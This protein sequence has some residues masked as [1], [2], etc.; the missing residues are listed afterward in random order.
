DQGHKMSKSLGNVIA[1][2]DVIKQMG[3]EIVRLWVASA[4]TTSDV[5]VSKKILQ[6]AAEAYRKIRN[7][8]RYMLANTSDFDPKANAVDFK[9][10]GSVDQY[11]LV[12]LNDLVA[13]CLMAYDHFDFTSVY[14]QVFS[15][16]SND[17]SAFYL[18]FA[19]DVLYIDAADSRSR[20]SMQT[21]IYAALVKL[22]KLL[23]PILPHT[24]EE[25]WSY[26]QEPEAYAQLADMPVVENY[27]NADE[28][29]TN[30]AAFMDLRS[31]V[32][33]ALE[34][35]R[36]Q[37][38]IGKSFEAKLTL[39]PTAETKAVLDKL[40]ANVQQILI[41]SQLTIADEPAP[42]DTE[43]FASGAVKVEHAQGEVCPRCRMIKND[44]G[45]DK[46]LPML[47]ARCAQIVADNYPAALTEGLDK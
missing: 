23:T 29:K 36:D 15:F 42:A 31:D 39:Y 13:D 8:M 25:V 34:E 32:L 43:Q 6:Q 9:D 17:L 5:A 40:A 45:T 41:I 12:K 11:M 2:S 19:K 1:P 21:V 3:A 18:D 20:R 7:T 10:L 27:P 28:L 24:M 30:W 37:K 22:T 47:C 14:K 16:L 26:L 38:L 4:D 44:L 33:K 46:R 35:A